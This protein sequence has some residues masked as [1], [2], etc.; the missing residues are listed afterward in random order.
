M[1][2]KIIN[3]EEYPKFN[4]AC[5]YICWIVKTSPFSTTNPM[6]KKRAIKI[7]AQREKEGKYFK[8]IKAWSCVQAKN[9]EKVGLYK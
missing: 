9:L 2:N 7:I 3:Y 6:T 4:P 8:L 5:K 1:K